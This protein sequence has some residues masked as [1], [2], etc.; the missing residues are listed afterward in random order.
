MLP[1]FPIVVVIVNVKDI[2]SQALMKN[3]IPSLP[4][5]QH[6]D[7]VRFKHCWGK[8]EM[9]TQKEKKCSFRLSEWDEGIDT[10]LSGS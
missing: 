8:E 2:I 3:L 4:Q 6:H 1:S 9:R 7:V 5:H 10:R